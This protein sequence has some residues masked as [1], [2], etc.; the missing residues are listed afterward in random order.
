[1]KSLHATISLM[2]FFSIT[3]LSLL[4][5]QTIFEDYE[6]TDSFIFEDCEMTDGSCLSPEEFKEISKD[7][8]SSVFISAFASFGTPRASELVAMKI[9]QTRLQEKQ[10]L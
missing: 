7:I 8:P 6:M 2:F 5:D 4:A 9:K 1:M 3:S 10:S